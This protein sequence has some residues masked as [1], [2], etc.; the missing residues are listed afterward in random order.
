MLVQ[1]ALTTHLLCRPV[2][3]A[4]SMGRRWELQ[5]LCEMTEVWYFDALNISGNARTKVNSR[6]PWVGIALVVAAGMIYL[7]RHGTN[8]PKP[9]DAEPL[10]LSLW[11][12]GWV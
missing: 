9:K 2:S 3:T 11:S 4:D 6:R 1:P 10:S 5:V 12:G 8:R 7:Q